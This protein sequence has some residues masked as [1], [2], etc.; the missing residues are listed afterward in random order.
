LAGGPV[1]GSALC[2][3]PTDRLVCPELHSS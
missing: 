2:I 1:A 3:Y